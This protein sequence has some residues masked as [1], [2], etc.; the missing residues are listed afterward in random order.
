M[1][2]IFYR[3]CKYQGQE[4]IECVI[5]T[6]V[7]VVDSIFIPKDYI[8]EIKLFQARTNLTFFNNN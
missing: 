3:F 1:V 5:N 7:K 6:D 8:T 4:V 2:K